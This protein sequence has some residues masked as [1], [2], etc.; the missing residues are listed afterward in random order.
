MEIAQILEK[1]KKQMADIT[2]LRAETI[3]RVFKDVEGWHVG[4]ELLEMSRIPTATDMLG[5]YEALISD[6]G[7][8]VR[9]VRRRTR[10]RG[11]PME[12]DGTEAD[13]S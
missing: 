11:E 13:H 8:L 7:G 5:S 3:T 10:L 2:G 6:A 12:E 4:V 1:S 9:F